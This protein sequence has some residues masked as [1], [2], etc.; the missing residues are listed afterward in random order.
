MTAYGTT[1]MVDGAI[2][3]GA[4]RVMTKPFDMHELDG[5]VREAHASRV[6]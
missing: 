3:R 5:I 2:A 1:E 4:Q 6:H